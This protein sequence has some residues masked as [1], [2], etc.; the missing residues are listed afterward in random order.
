[1]RDT[2]EYLAVACPLVQ[3]R[4]LMTMRY[5]LKTSYYKKRAC[6]VMEE[7]RSQILS[8]GSQPALKSAVYDVMSLYVCKDGE[9]V[10]QMVGF[11]NAEQDNISNLSMKQCSRLYTLISNFVKEFEA[12]PEGM[13]TLD[14]YGHIAE[15]VQ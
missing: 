3:H 7:I 10:S 11:V 12:I 9:Y 6:A 13:R 14:Y 8:L 4:A 15:L 5:F 1:M 2:K